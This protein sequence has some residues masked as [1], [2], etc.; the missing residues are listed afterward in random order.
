MTVVNGILGGLVGVTASC[1]VVNVNESLVIGAIGSFLA[2]VTAPLLVWLR[3][4]DAVG[5]TC[6]HGFGGAWGM[7]AV[8]LFARKDKLAGG[9]SAYDG[10]IWG[11]ETYL[12]GIQ[13]LATCLLLVWAM[14]STYIL[15]FMI[16]LI[17]PI[18]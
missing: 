9:F 14:T 4:D 15:L 5:A 10:F 17:C 6:V 12:L 7:I 1:A 13:T 11:G 2:N 8:G 3:V 16:D 18:R